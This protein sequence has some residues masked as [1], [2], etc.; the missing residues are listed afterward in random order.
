MSFG[1]LYKE[2]QTL[3]VPVQTAEIR[4]IVGRLLNGRRAVV[5]KQDLDPNLIKGYYISPR[6]EDSL[7]RGV[8][9]GAAVIVVA[10]VLDEPWARYVELKELMHLFDDPMHTTNIG[11]E[12]E[13][14][15]AG[16][17]ESVDPDRA[18]RSPQ[19]QSEYECEWMAL[20]LSCPEEIRVDLQRRREEKAITDQEIANILGIPGVLVI[21]LM[22]SEY[23]ASVAWLLD[24]Y[25]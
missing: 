15:L 25:S 19:V 5:V 16:L 20:A 22:S 12:L 11:A 9:P 23:K 10:K 3:S 1:A 4:S 24:K 18:D 21:P 13:V 7:F 17:C 6:N 8:P 14:L 2:V